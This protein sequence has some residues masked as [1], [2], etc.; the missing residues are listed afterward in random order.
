[1]A[2]LGE[3]LII[4]D[5]YISHYFSLTF[6]LREREFQ[7]PVSNDHVFPTCNWFEE[8][9]RHVLHQHGDGSEPLLHLIQC[10]VI[11][12]PSCSD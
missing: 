10:F 7:F 6:Q 8:A 3:G 12:T 4:Q 1:M 9:R 2:R 11:H 5:L